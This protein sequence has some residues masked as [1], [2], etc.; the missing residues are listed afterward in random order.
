MQPN[1]PLFTSLKLCSD[2]TCCAHQR[3]T[4]DWYKYSNFAKG[5]GFS[6]KDC[7][8][9]VL[10]GLFYI[11]NCKLWLLFKTQIT[12]CYFVKFLWRMP[13]IW[14]SIEE[15]EILSTLWIL[16]CSD[17]IYVVLF[18]LMLSFIVVICF[19]PPI[20]INKCWYFNMMLG[21]NKRF[22]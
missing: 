18:Y 10:L 12:A 2:I 21:L 22:N 9:F 17:F 13:I 3:L 5:V 19:V 16:T 20:L 14:I 1:W 7:P 6:K 8:L 4:F 15:L 11:E